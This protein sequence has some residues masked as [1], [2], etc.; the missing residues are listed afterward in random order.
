MS[1]ARCL[2]SSLYQPS[3]SHHSPHRRTQTARASRWTSSS[4]LTAPSKH[5]PELVTLGRAAAFALQC[6][7]APPSQRLR[8]Q[9]TKLH[10]ARSFPTCPTKSSGL[11]TSPPGASLRLQPYVQPPVHAHAIVVCFHKSFANTFSLPLSLLSPAA[12][13][14]PPERQLPSRRDDPRLGIDRRHWTAAPALLEGVQS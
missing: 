7:V 4:T 14:R 6:L 9:R 13:P 10:P 5:S 2:R 3:L 11:P 12:L 8:A 1:S